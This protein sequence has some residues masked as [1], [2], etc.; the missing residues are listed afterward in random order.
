MRSPP[1]GTWC[2]CGTSPHIHTM[3]AKRAGR[4]AGLV[5]DPAAARCGGLAMAGPARGRRP[6]QWAAEARRPT[7]RRRHARASAGRLTLGSRRA[8]AGNGRNSGAERAFSPHATP[9]GERHGNP[10]VGE[11]SRARRACPMRRLCRSFTVTVGP[12]GSQFGLPWCPGMGP[13]VPDL[14]FFLGAMQEHGQIVANARVTGLLVAPPGSKPHAVRR[15]Q[16]RWL[17][18][19]ATQLVI[20]WYDEEGCGGGAPAHVGCQHGLLVRRRPPT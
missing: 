5:Q 6:A 15:I 1:D 14:K 13:I 3:C 18:T 8:R 10:Q 16:T 9:T 17:R 4:R 12:E 11:P 19:R 2:G 20:C 7:Q